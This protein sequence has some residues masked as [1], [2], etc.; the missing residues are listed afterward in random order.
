MGYECGNP[1]QSDCISDEGK[2]TFRTLRDGFSG[3]THWNEEKLFLVF[4]PVR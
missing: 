4:G 2:S 3:W 1:S